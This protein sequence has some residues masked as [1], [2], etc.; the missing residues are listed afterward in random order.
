M[1]HMFYTV[2]GAVVGVHAG[3]NART[4]EMMTV[5]PDEGLWKGAQSGAVATAAAAAAAASKSAA[6]A[7]VTD[8][9]VVVGGG[10]SKGEEEARAGEK[11]VAAG[12]LEGELAVA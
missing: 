12:S 1:R 8:V 9:K 11:V 6:A 3:P 10:D 2:L 4:M 5:M 7:A